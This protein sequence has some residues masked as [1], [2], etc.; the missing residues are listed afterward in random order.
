MSNGCLINYCPGYILETLSEMPPPCRPLYNNDLDLNFVDPLPGDVIKEPAAPRPA[1]A[2]GARH[3]NAPPQ[4]STLVYLARHGQTESNVQGRYAGYSDESITDA[5]RGQ[6]SAL[7]LRLAPCGVGEV[8]T[9][10]VPRARDSAEV[11]AQVLGT[12]L[13][14]DARLNEMR[15]GPWE[16][17]TEEEVA[18]AFPS[19]HA[20]WCV[21]PDQLVLEGRETLDEVA[22]RVSSAVS[23]AARQKHPVLLLSHVAPI[24]VAVL[25]ALGLPLSRYKG[26]RM[27]NGDGVVIDHANDQARRVGED[28][29]LQD[30]LPISGPK[31]SI[32]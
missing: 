27:D 26:L 21:L 5:G 28:R 31:S 20:L 19:A 1:S 22:A 3:S 7:A 15:L 12:P 11:V 24:R 4:Q 10:E 17:M 18:R 6:M 2:G 23:D 8:W 16:G 30:E 29:S 9:S 14:V 13:R 32:A 25:T